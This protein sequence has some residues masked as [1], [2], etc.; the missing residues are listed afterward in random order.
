LGLCA[1]AY[2]A[3]R[4]VVFEPGSELEVCGKRELSFFAGTAV[5]AVCAGFNYKNEQGAQV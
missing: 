5:G 1:G 3:C 4:N 2:Y